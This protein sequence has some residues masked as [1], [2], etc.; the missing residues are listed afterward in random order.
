MTPT[1]PQLRWGREGGASQRSAG[2]RRL[3]APAEQW[4]LGGLADLFQDLPAACAFVAVG[5]Q[6]LDGDARHVGQ[7]EGA[8]RALILALAL[9]QL[10]VRGDEDLAEVEP[11]ERLQ[12]L[13]RGVDPRGGLQAR[14]DA[15]FG[16]LELEGAGDAAAEGP[17][18]LP[19]LPGR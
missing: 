17:H 6:R 10:A 3:P 14:P 15:L 8:R 7:G 9:E 2:P 19:P 16:A 11:L 4:V 18:P 5:G 13:G 1:P 12:V